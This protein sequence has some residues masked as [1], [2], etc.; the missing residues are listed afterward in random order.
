MFYQE[1]KPFYSQNGLDGLR[2]RLV[3]NCTEC[4]FKEMMFVADKELNYMFAMN[5]LLNN[6]QQSNFV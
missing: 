4:K 6:I 3:L 2:T 5:S 1:R